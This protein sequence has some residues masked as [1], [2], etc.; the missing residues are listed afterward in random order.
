[1]DNKQIIGQKCEKFAELFF[2]KKGWELTHRNWKY[3]HGEIDLIFEKHD[4]IYFIEVRSL[5]AYFSKKLHYATGCSIPACIIE[6]IFPVSK[7]LI[8][9]RTVTG[10][11]VEFHHMNDKKVSFELFVVVKNKY[12]HFENILDFS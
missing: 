10:F 5:K 8:L 7:Q 4:T 1:M 2:E 12:C 9:K 6:K 3:G 11:F